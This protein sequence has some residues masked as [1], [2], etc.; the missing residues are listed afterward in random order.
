MKKTLLFAAVTAAAASLAAVPGMASAADGQ[1][2]FSGKVV[3]QTCQ[4]NGNGVGSQPTLPTVALPQVMTP[5]LLANGAVAGATP[6]S[7]SITGCDSSL[8]TVATQF[9]GSNIDTATDS[10][11]NTAANG[12]NNVE[13]QLLNGDSTPIKLSGATATAQQ[14]KAASLSSGAATLNYIAQYRSLGNAS[15]GPVTSNVQFTMIYQ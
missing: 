14:S 2:N 15:A 13:L 6:F 3:A 9:S 12:A 11:K 10:L 1:I 4:I 7:I 8:S 5:T